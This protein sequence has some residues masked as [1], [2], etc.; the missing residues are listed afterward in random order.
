MLTDKPKYSVRD[1]IKERRPLLIFC[2]SKPHLVTFAN[3][4][5][6]LRALQQSYLSQSYTSYRL[7]S[8]AW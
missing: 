2:A 5:N 3:Y 1:T 6:R 8:R 4:I 7:F